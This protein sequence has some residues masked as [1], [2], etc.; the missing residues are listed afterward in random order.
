M[1]LLLT[2]SDQW[3]DTYK[4]SSPQQQY[5][6][7]IEA[8]SADPI[9]LDYSEKIYFIDPLLEMEDRLISNNLVAQLFFLLDTLEQ[10]QPDLY[11]EDF[12]YFD[13]A[14]IEYYLF[15]NDLERVQAALLRFKADPVKGID[16]LCPMLDQL[17]LYGVT[18]LA[19]DLC[20]TT[21]PPIATS[22]ELMGGTQHDFGMVVIMACFE[23]AYHQLQQGQTVD[24]HGMAADA[25]VY[26]F[27]TEDQ[28]QEEVAKHLT[29]SVE[30]N[31]DFLKLF[32]RDRGQALRQ[33]LLGFCRE[34]YD[35]QQMSFICSQLLWE[36]LLDALDR[37][38]RS[39]K[40][41]A[42]PDSYFMLT[43]KVLDRHA[44]QLV[45]GFMSRQQPRGFALLWGIPY[46]YEFLQARGVISERIAQKVIQTATTLKQQL[47]KAFQKRLW[48]YSFV[49]HWQPPHMISEANFNAEAEQFATSIEQTQ[50]LSDEPGKEPS[51]E[52][53]LEAAV[54]KLE[55][56]LDVPPQ[57]QS[58]SPAAQTQSSPPV[59]PLKQPKAR[60][61][62][63]REAA[64]LPRK[65]KETKS[66][67]RKSK[68]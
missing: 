47:I 49:H 4:E 15:R 13:S 19:V 32:K 54:E 58:S 1:S 44:S 63:L 52:Q 17:R 6:L 20:R 30:G 56:Q 12:H 2:D 45:A 34:L 33:L 31:S 28:R 36:V 43:Q 5:D 48:R 40:Q 42:H 10:K 29:T 61:S 18:A 35:H 11:Q 16:E 27:V 50:P 9:P 55:A 7:L 37:Q 22:S 14:R 57:S 21:Y 41:L 26:G 39:Q 24:W 8:I 65:K 25:A 64:K 46:I 59:A 66:S 62:P 23:Q 67:K 38:D 3:Y 51:Y 60:K 53:M 68:N